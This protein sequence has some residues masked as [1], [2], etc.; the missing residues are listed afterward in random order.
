MLYL[1]NSINN[2]SSAAPLAAWPEYS[3][4]N[5]CAA[6]TAAMSDTVTPWRVPGGS[7][8]ERTSFFE[9]SAHVS[10]ILRVVYLLEALGGV[11]SYNRFLAETLILGAYCYIAILL[12]QTT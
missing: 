12:T 7:S 10:W 4:R 3:A 6:Q 11:S 2:S 9:A 1:W 5:R 8:H